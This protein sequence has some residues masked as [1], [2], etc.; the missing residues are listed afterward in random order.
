MLPPSFIVLEGPRR[1]GGGKG[2]KKPSKKPPK[3]KKKRK[4]NKTLILFQRIELEKR[5]FHKIQMAL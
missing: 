1:K 5:M 2:K 3:T 4:Q